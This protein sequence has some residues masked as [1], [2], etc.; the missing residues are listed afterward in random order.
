MSEQASE[1]EMNGPEVWNKKEGK[2]IRKMSKGDGMM[3]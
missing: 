1:T 2:L 3:N